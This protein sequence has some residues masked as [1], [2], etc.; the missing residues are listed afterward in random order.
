MALIETENIRRVSHALGADLE[1]W[2]LDLD[3]YAAKV[4]L[5]GLSADEHAR[6]ARMAFER[7]AR[8]YLAS[9]HALRT[10]LAAA[11]DCPTESVAIKI[12]EVDKPCLVDGGTLQF[13]I[14]HCANA[15]L[16]ALS[17]STPIGVDIE[18]VRPITDAD[19]LARSHFTDE[20]LAAWLSAAEP[21]RDQTFLACWTRKEACLKALGV[22]LSAP[23][24]T[25]NAG[26]S[27]QVRV[28][29]VPLGKRQCT[30]TVYPL[31]VSPETV[32]AVALA[33]PEAVALARRFYQRS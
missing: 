22:G 23:P 1:F 17:R 7:D 30:L 8:R 21:M 16:I 24:S 5:H 32:A 10:V 20:E 4:P 6:A 14:S 33:G 15:G 25:V 26:C 27:P 9:R 13:N 29:S 12:D 19:A 11:L 3:A 2:R 28:L 31:E 18:V